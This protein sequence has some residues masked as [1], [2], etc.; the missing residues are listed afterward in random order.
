MALNNAQLTIFKAAILAETDPVVVTA[1]SIGDDTGVA[2]WYNS[3]HAT[4]T[5][6]KTYLSE[7]TIVGDVSPEATVWN[8]TDYIATS[9]AEKMAW[10][11]IF[12]GTY[13]INPSLP[14]VRTGIAAIFSGPNGADQRTHLLAIAKRLATRGEALFATGT[15]TQGSPG[16]LT[17]EGMIVHNDVRN[18]LNLP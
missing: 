13:S 9:T 12:N 8:W 6:W 16:T 17:F 11:R 7:H 3:P 18:A 14:Q 4:F 1:V 5:V 10:E 2:N 15:G